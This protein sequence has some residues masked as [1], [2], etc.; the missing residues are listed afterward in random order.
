MN[1]ILS[2]TP[3]HVP[4]LDH[5]L[6]GGLPTR[7]ISLVAGGSGCGKS[8]LAAQFLA[9]GARAGE[10]GVLVTFE[11]DL[12]D[13]RRDLSGF[14]FAFGQ[15][16]ETGSIEVL[17]VDPGAFPDATTGSFTL[18]GLLLQLESAIEK[19]S[20]KRVA[21]DTLESV[22]SELGESGSLRRELRRLFRWLEARGVTTLVTAEAGRGE[23]FTR[24]GLEEYVA[25]CVILLDFRI[26]N[27]LGTRRARVLKYRGGP[28]SGDEHPFLIGS[29]G[30]ELIPLTASRLEHEATR[31]RISTGIPSLDEM[32][33]G[34]GVHRG[35][36]TL[37]SGSPGAGKSSLG[38]AFVQGA[39][40]RGERALYLSFEESPEQI[41]RNMGAVGYDLRPWVDE[42]R[43]DIESWRPSQRG[44]EGHLF[45]IQRAVEEHDPR[46]MVVDP[47]TSIAVSEESGP[48]RSMLVRL[49]DFLKARG[50]TTM[51]TALEAAD[52][53]GHSASNSHVSSLMDTWV[54]LEAERRE[55]A[56]QRYGWILK[57]RGIEHSR[58]V[59]QLAVTDEGVTF[60][61][62]NSNTVAAD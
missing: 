58:Y 46:V 6:G 12:D 31:E 43:L 1:D 40:R 13:L 51:F 25:D 24:R 15:H 59:R 9:G 35:S 36:S 42:G 18:D 21:V 33:A 32:L 22:I 27:E 55:G 20:A 7:R 3:T 2:K 17:H 61:A 19:V 53:S 52:V 5:I 29:N 26:Q 23:A 14:D 41:L 28:H 16:V 57:S 10:P 4:G 48:S 44:L 47:F 60:V 11:Q 50:V 49:V 37:V 30:I 38:A 39:C 8:V 45:G 62:T 56:R 54:V 34:T